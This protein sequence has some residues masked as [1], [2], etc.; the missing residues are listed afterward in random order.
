ASIDPSVPLYAVESA[1]GCELVL[2]DGR[3][4]IDGMSSWWS[5]IHGYNRPELNEALSRQAQQM[6]HVMFG[7]LTHE[8]AVALAKK[9]VDL[10]PK[11]LEKVFF[12]DSG[13]V[14]VEV[15]IKMALQ[16]HMS[17]GKPEKN[18]ILSLRKAYHGD[19]LGAM[20]LCDPV[21]GMHHLFQSILPQ[22][23]FADAPECTLREK[24]DPAS[25]HSLKD[26]LRSHHKTIAAFILE[27]VVQGTGGMNFYHPEYLREA[28]LLCN[29][30]DV[31]LIADEIATGF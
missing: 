31:L 3:R 19:T 30:F 17:Q 2:H 18:R 7:G 22:Q 28:R 1:Q 12:A 4:L 21:T 20:S 16:Y 29:Q 13:S 24:W 6:A 26:L 14:S 11:G 25:L 9:L 8:P 5:A 10:T 15:A 23:L 27:P